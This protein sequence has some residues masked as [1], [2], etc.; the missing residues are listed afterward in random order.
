MCTVVV[1]DHQPIVA[2]GLKSLLES[3]TNCKIVGIAVNGDELLDALYEHHPDILILEIDIPQINGT[4]IL[5][6]IK[7][8]FPNT[9]VLIFSSLPEEIYA[10]RFIKSGAAKYINKSAS[11]KLLLDSIEALATGESL[12]EYE[13]VDATVLHH[14]GEKNAIKRYNKLSLREIDV[15]N[16][17]SK[18]KRN[19]DIAEALDINEKTVSTY[20]KRILTKMKAD[21]IVDL[22][23][24]SKMFT[25]N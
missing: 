14:V 11:T 1:A 10:S 23:N 7:S 17:M 2:K 8:Q 3:K 25:Y 18:G 4:H 20:K 13:Y 15:L 12:Q 5:R 19:K 24:F 9:R 21:N 6:T 16:M 22:I